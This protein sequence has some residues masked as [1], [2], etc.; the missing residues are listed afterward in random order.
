MVNFS[1]SVMGSVETG[2]MR[3]ESDL[4]AH[5]HE[6]QKIDSAKTRS[7]F[8]KP[9]LSST[10]VTGWAHYITSV[11]SKNTY[12]SEF[13]DRSRLCDIETAES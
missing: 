7:R 3:T 10:E 5:P 4:G 13:A 12:P 9:V 6:K 8:R 2:V 11:N 1:G